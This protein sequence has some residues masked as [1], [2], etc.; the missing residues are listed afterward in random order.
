MKCAVTRHTEHKGA[1]LS[2][3]VP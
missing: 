3:S 2:Y 1:V